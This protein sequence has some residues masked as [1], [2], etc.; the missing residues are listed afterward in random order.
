[1][2]VHENY[3]SDIL[4]GRRSGEKYKGKIQEMVNID[5]SGDG[6]KENII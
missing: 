6:P 2:L 1:M 5:K 4:R 3:L